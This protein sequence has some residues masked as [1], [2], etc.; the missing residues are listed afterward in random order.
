M[1]KEVTKAIANGKKLEVQWDSEG[2]S[3]G[4]HAPQLKSF[5]GTTVKRL[6][7]ITYSKWPSVPETLKDMVWKEVLVSLSICKIN[8]KT[9]TS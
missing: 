6:V 2:Q 4:T 7:A 3:I 9:S 1:S 8:F 5:I